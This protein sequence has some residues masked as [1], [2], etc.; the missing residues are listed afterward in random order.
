MTEKNMKKTISLTLLA[1]AAAAHADDA[2][3]TQKLHAFGLKTVEI[4]DSP[5]PGLRSVI[6]EQGIFYATEDGKYYLQGDLVELG[7]NGPIDLSNRPLLP[8][9]EALKDEM[10]LFPAKNEKYAITVF[11]DSSC[12][13][14]QLLHKDIGALNERGITVR[15]LAFPR[16]GT[17]SKIAR[18]ME[19]VFSAPENRAKLLEDLESGKD[20]AETRADKVKK[21]YQLGHQLGVQGTPA[22]ITP[23]GALIP[24]YYKP[25]DLLKLLQKETSS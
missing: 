5:V 20:I 19:T 24:G 6:T 16:S 22:I 1:L 12:H 23:K 9:L 3:I 15:Y 21:H 14:C 8:K 10:I 7:D 4:G 13:Y 2:A 11:F 18:Q 25:D 17:G